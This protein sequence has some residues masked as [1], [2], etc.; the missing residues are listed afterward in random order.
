MTPPLHCLMRI[1]SIINLMMVNR[2]AAVWVI[3][4]EVLVVC[5]R[6]HQLECGGGYH[7]WHSDLC[8]EGGPLV[9]LD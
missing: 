1:P 2:L 6:D 3:G 7:W 9:H 4:R 8:T 5:K